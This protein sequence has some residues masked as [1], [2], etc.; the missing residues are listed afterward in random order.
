MGQ[1]Q[2][3]EELKEAIQGELGAYF[4]SA[5][6]PCS[7]IADPTLSSSCIALVCLLILFIEAGWLR[8]SNS[9][10]FPPPRALHPASL[11]SFSQRGLFCTLIR[12]EY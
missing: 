10:V 7:P 4:V 1:G 6:P 11:C 8:I 2:T 5:L 12:A 3:R 9:G